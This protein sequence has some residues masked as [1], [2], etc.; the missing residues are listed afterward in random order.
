M[1]LMAEYPD[2]HFDLAVVD[3][4]YGI[5]V[6]K[7]GKLGAS[8]NERWSNPK[9]KTYKIAE[10]DSEP[11]PIEYFDELFRVSKN[12]IIW[13][14]NHFMDKVM[15]ASPSWI[16]WDKK[17]GDN[18]YADAELAYTSHKKSVRI[19]EGLWKGFQRCEVV[20]RIHPTQKP[21][22]LYDW[23]FANY[24]DKGMKILDTH[25]GS[26]SSAIAC[27]YASMH[28]TGCELDEDYFKAGC[29]RVQ[30]ET[31]QLMFL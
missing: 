5:G 25:L 17:T 13:G 18:N 4:P 26:M 9:Q 12:Q 10:W 6:C 22:K 7:T 30:R 27:H 15:R 1:E 2:N 19:W 23:I 11:P 3:P 21:V 28:L 16:V 24:A 8:S 29:E 14:A 31:R 20:D